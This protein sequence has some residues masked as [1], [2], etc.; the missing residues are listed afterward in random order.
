MLCAHHCQDPEADVWWVQ[1]RSFVEQQAVALVLHPIEQ[2]LKTAPASERDGPH[3]RDR[4]SARSLMQQLSS[5]RGEAAGAPALVRGLHSCRNHVVC[6]GEEGAV[7]LL[8][9]AAPSS[10]HV[11][12]QPILAGQQMP[13]TLL[14]NK[15]RPKA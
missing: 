5:R 1:V 14:Q 6:T 11:I 3:R 12:N 2:I 7:R 9:S 8:P 10:S 13:M 4:P 15:Q